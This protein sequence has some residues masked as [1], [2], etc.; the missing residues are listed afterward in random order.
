MKNKFLQFL[1]SVKTKVLEENN[2]NDFEIGFR[3]ASRCINSI[4]ETRCN[5]FEEDVCNVCDCSLY[6]EDCINNIISTIKETFDN[7]Q[8]ETDFNKG[9][10]QKSNETIEKLEKFK[11]H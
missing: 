3:C 6:I 8:E 5:I 2:S 9:Y 11:I 4:I 1:N 7:K 10:K